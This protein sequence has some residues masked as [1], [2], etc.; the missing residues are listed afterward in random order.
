MRNCVYGGKSCWN[1]GLCGAMAGEYADKAPELPKLFLKRLRSVEQGYGIAF[2]IGTTTV[3]GYLCDLKER[4][5]IA[6]NAITNPQITHGR[7]ASERLTYAAESPERATELKELL[8]RHLSELTKK[9]LG[10]LDL[11]NVV[12]LAVAGNPAMCSLLSGESRLIESDAELFIF[13]GL[14]DSIGGDVTAGLFAA[15]IPKLKGTSLYVD[16]GTST[17]LA[18]S[19]DGKLYTC[20]SS[21][22]PV[23][24]GGEISRGMRAVPGAINRLKITDVFV[25]M[26]TVKQEIPKGICGAGIA[27]AVAALLSAGI[28]SGEGRFISPD[29]SK[30]RLSRNISSL[31]REKSEGLAF[32]LYPGIN[33][34]EQDLLNVFRATKAVYSDIQTLLGKAG[35]TIDRIDRVFMA[36]PYENFIDTVSAVALGLVPDIGDQNIFHIGNG[37]G[38]GACMALLSPELR[39]RSGK[40]SNSVI[41]A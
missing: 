27:D 16:I 24:E 31:L 40:L 19:L 5:I 37:A 35:I 8:V 26:D 20:A 3:A 11:S 38:I 18:L 15:D 4:A 36:G 41:S 23:F 10:S 33:F 34:T 13:P 22:G 7:S 9:L 14:S 17:E 2:D 25:R 29:E 30:N 32:E 6:H 28:A 12:R 1:C 39:E 21:A